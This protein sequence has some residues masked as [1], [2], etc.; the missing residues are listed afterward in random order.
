MAYVEAHPDLPTR[1][2]QAIVEGVP[3]KGMTPEQVRAAMGDPWRTNTTVAEYGTREQWVYYDGQV[4]VYLTDGR[5]TA[6][7]Y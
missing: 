7:Q 5:V 4:Y 3:A 2:M 1:I 6:I